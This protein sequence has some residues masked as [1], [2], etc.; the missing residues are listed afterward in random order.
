MYM[1]PTIPI[2]PSI[3]HV[4]P[5]NAVLRCLPTQPPP[6]PPH[7][8]LPYKKISPIVENSH[9][10]PYTDSSGQGCFFVNTSSM[11]DSYQRVV[12]LPF[13]FPVYI[14]LLP[15]PF[16]FPNCS[17][18]VLKYYILAMMCLCHCDILKTAISVIPYLFCHRS[19]SLAP[20]SPS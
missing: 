8:V 2:F 17:L 10:F 12:V 13:C 18:L 9:D 14:L 15:S 1:I 11:G 4:L 6:P 7:T 16:P 20:R 5:A 19:A 3:T